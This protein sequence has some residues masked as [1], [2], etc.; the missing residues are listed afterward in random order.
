MASAGWATLTFL[1]S[2]RQDADLDVEAFSAL[3]ER[4]VSDISGAKNRVRYAMNGFV[5]AVGCNI[6]ALTAKAT[7]CAKKIGKV[8]VDMGGTACKVPL[9][10]QYIQKVIDRGSVG[11]KRKIYRK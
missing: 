6:T 10:T 8:S 4:A 1:S 5:I 11:K 9:A 3:L 7:A 2:L